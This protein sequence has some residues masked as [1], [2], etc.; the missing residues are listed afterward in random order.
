M[1]QSPVSWVD[2]ISP[3]FTFLMVIVA[4][5]ILAGWVIIRTLKDNPEAAPVADN[6]TEVEES[7]LQ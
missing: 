6:D 5:T 1:E 3:V 2:V 7:T 4:P